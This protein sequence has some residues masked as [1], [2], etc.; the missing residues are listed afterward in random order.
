MARHEPLWLSNADNPI[1]H[2]TQVSRPPPLTLHMFTSY[3]TTHPYYPDLPPGLREPLTLACIAETHRNENALVL[4]GY[5]SLDTRAQT[6]YATFQTIKNHNC[7]THK[8]F[9]PLAYN[10]PHT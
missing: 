3:K 5:C 1:T 6:L 2:L 4:Y 10:N 7:C 9:T 8:S